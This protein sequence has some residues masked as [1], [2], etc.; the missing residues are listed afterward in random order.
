M[1]TE[2]NLSA[3]PPLNMG[4]RVQLSVMMFLQFAIW[5]A[6]FLVFFPY[7]I[8][9]KFD[10][11]QAGA[12]IGN[13]ALGAIF[14]SLFA[15]FIADRFVD[16]R[17]IMAA[18]HVAGGGLLYFVTQYTSPGDYWTLYALTLGYALLYNPTLVLANAI[19]FR[20]VPD[21]G[22]DFPGVRVFGTIGWIA[23]G[24]FVDKV[25]P[26]TGL[27]AAGAMSSESGAPLLL[28]AILSVVLGLFCLTLPKT[29]PSGSPGEGLPLAKAFGL[30]RNPSF[31]VFFGVSLAITLVLAFYYTVTGD[32][33][34]EQ[35]GIT[36]VP[37]TMS[38][39]QVC[40]LIFLPLLPLFLLRLGM[41]WVLALGMLCWGV[42]Y[43]CFSQ[44]GPDGLPFALAI[45]GVALH[46]VC[47][48][49]FF[50]A[51]FIYCDNEAPSDI[52]AS[53]QALFS[54]LTYGVGMWL[55]SLACG[56]LL[57]YYTVS[58]DG[59]KVIDWQSFWLVPAVGV[60]ACCAV[61]VLFFRVGKSRS[62]AVEK[63]ISTPVG[64]SADTGV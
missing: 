23:A 4:V 32:F 18:C 12:L 2:T 10:G 54:F 42:R 61:F 38:I 5:G 19:T 7:L 1:A 59:A 47:F 57:D 28:S 25:L 33:L 49:F 29:P 40:E 44:A 55:G 62:P 46:G 37:T 14:S 6:W 45:A 21:G 9:L 16:A 64:A 31:A 27:M 11:L 20:H 48:D 52:R 13:M 36:E 41:K 22:R 34:K 58:A 8:H 56:A 24:L 15:G 43:L 53:A 17:L 35:V 39:G 50:A 3:A 51:G 63:D 60:L 30:F 26:H